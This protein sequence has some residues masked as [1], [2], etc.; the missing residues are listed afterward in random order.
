MVEKMSFKIED[1][2][3]F[4]KY[5]VFRKK[6]K[7][8]LNIKCYSQSIYDEKYIKTRVKTFNDV[9][10]VFSDN[11]IPIERNHFTCIAAMFWF[12]HEDR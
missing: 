4:F 2:D 6:I 7:K 11:E 9:I 12:C 8:A 3:T 10:I 5:T 1:D